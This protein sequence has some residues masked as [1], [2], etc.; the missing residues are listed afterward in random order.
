MSMTAL[1]S[2]FVRS[3]ALLPPCLRCK[4]EGAAATIVAKL[5]VAMTL[6]FIVNYNEW[7]L[8]K[9]MKEGDRADLSIEPI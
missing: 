3:F 7:I 9:G 6:S 1:H 4:V 8:T 5:R 2:P